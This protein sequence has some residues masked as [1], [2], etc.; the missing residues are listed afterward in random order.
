MDEGLTFEEVKQKLHFTTHTPVPAGHDVFEFSEAEK[1]L[2]KQHSSFCKKFASK[3]KLSM[4]HLAI[5]VSQT[6]NAV[7]KLNAKVAS[8]M[9]P[10]KK[11]HQLLM[12]SSPYLTSAPLAKLYD[13]EIHGENPSE[14]KKVYDIDDE[15]FQSHLIRRRVLDM[16]I[17]CQ[18]EACH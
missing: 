5:T 8:E 1:I 15:K 14:L 18:A 2:G 13:I 3:G 7:S 11:F 16:Q 17:R 6:C 10:D 4:S 9:F 12:S